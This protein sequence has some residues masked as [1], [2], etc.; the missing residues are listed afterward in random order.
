MSRAIK[1]EQTDQFGLP[2]ALLGRSDISRV[3]RELERIDSILESQAIRTPESP[4][5]IPSMSRALTDCVTLNNV[6]ITDV[7]ERQRL[8]KMLRQTK[9]KAPVVHITFAVDPIP[10]IT[11]QITIWIRENLHSQA[12]VSVGLQP[13]IVGGC[14]VRTPDH[15]YDFS[16]RKRFKDSEA[17][18]ISR[19][20]QVVA[21]QA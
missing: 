6:M 11:A 2:P 14:I 19:L 12:L 9:D 7:N 21:E 8:I 13:R 3:L 5:V 17:V 16:I 20:N 15:I 18:L 4:Q 10:A 1:L